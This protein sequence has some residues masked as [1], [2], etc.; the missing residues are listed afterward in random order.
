[1]ITHTAKLPHGYTVEF[2]WVLAT[3]FHVLW[4]PAVPD[5]RS[6][7]HRA[8][9]MAAYAAER[10]TFTEM[11]AASLGKRVMTVTA[12]GSTLAISSIIAPP[13]QQ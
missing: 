10:D 8:K 11:V 13:T 3:G 12:D 4:E 5:I 2:R 7:R 1:M 6:G 9:F